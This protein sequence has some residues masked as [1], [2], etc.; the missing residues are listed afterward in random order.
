M[1]GIPPTQ[2]AI[3]FVGPDEV[4]HN[5]AKPVGPVGPRQVLARI[6]AV[7]ICFSDTKLLHAWTAHPR[8]G[9]VVTG[10]S[11]DVLAEIPSYVPGERPTVPG[12]EVCARIVA[13][14]DAVTRHQVGE[15][16]LV[17]TDYRTLMTS[18]AN[19]AFGYDFE[20]GL[21]E[22]VVLDERMIIEPE[23]GERFLIPVGE[24]PS[25]SS[26]ALIEPWACVERAY[27]STERGQLKAG[28][29]SLVVVEAGRAIQGLD[30]LVT[31][32]TPGALVA[33]VADAEQRVPLEALCSAT[34]VTL[35]FAAET[36]ALPPETFDDIIYLGADPARLEH[37]QGL[38]ALGGVLDVV[39]GGKPLGRPVQV[40]VGRIHYDLVRW[41]GTT[42]PA[43]DEGY[44]WAPAGTEL[45]D[46]DRV[47]VIG[48]AGPM[49]F[50]H[51]IRALTSGRRDLSLVAVDIDESRLAH[52][53]SVAAPMAEARGVGF[54]TVNSS[55]GDPGSDFTHVGVMV[56]IPAIAAGALEMAGQGA[57]IDLFAG[58]AVGTR[59]AIDVD[60]LLAR[61]AYLFGTSGS[62]ID[63]MKAV[64]GRL[65]GGLLDTDI[66]VYAVSGLEGV[67]E[68]LEAVKARTSGGKIVIY[69]QLRSMGMITLPDLERHYPEVA[70]A[71]DG[72]RWTR[73][74]EEAL[75]AAAGSSR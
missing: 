46:G 63:D 3:Q 68:A 35:T 69:P 62:I 25:A 11:Q 59:A 40:D 4:V 27:A 26:V 44:G 54:T 24:G 53:A 23:T 13:V 49:G 42:G 50:M 73:A 32:A 71:L 17:Q 58:F 60:M 51:V 6:E 66:S 43:A 39:L 37:L 21:Q 14:G 1:T 19:A 22:Y 61:Q 9:P 74:A 55:Q 5:R 72:G 2:H 65:E 10:I 18:K 8:K 45:R 16:V 7:G 30:T 48:A 47:A 36:E 28:G 20:G 29:R 12:H 52:L 75:L 57:L 38:L 34:G 64:L 70:A 31:A 41:L 33:V 56:P 67:A 15:R